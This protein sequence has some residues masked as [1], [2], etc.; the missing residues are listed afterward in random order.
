MPHKARHFFV[1]YAAA[2][3]RNARSLRSRAKRKRFALLFFPKINNW[4]EFIFENLGSADYEMMEEICDCCFWKDVVM[5]Y[6][7]D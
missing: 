6:L 3:A 1:I 7:I 5:W 2:A 4:L